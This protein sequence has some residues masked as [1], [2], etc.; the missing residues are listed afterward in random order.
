VVDR[1]GSSG[2]RRNGSSHALFVL[3]SSLLIFSSTGCGTI[4][5]I[6][7]PNHRGLAMGEAFHEVPP[8]FIFS[9]V[10]CDVESIEGAFYLGALPGL[11]V[12]VDV[13]FSFAADTLMLP[14][15]A[16]RHY[17]AYKPQSQLFKLVVERDDL[18]ENRFE[19]LSGTLI[20]PA[21][22]QSGSEYICQAEQTNI[23]SFSVLIKEVRDQYLT[24]ARGYMSRDVA[25]LGLKDGQQIRC[26]RDDSNPRWPSPR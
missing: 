18:D 23:R 24:L 21:N 15:Q 5:S 16:V 7:D 19:Q 22:V 20:S 25:A 2:T 3:I 9:G 12:L 8:R 11:M 4:L 13:P 14:I 17:E 6:R 1:V 10:R 26:Q